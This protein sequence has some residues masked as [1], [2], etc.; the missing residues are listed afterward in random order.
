M[1]KSA[2]TPIPTPRR[3]EKKGRPFRAFLLICCLLIVAVCFPP[4]FRP[5]VRSALKL[6]AAR[7]GLQLEVARIEGSL[8]GPV[9]FYDV[10][11]SGTSTAGSAVQL[12]AERAR[13]TFSWKNL[14]LR[15]GS[16]P[17]EELRV[18]NL[19]GTVDV[20]KESQ[21]PDEKKS[22]SS[23][24][25]SPRILFPAA[26]EVSDAS[27]MIKQSREFVRLEHVTFRASDLES[28]EI[29]IGALAVEQPW[30][31]T[32]FNNLRGTIALQN[33]QAT[34]AAMKLGD[35]L[36]L[37]NVSADLPELLRGRLKVNFAL[38][39]FSGTIRGELRSAPRDKHLNF[40]SS[41]GFSQIS[42]AQLAAFLDED[43][44]GVI[45]EGKFTFRGSPHDLP[46]ATFSTRFEATDF[47]WAKR[48]W[49][50]LR[51]GA[52]LINRRLMIP[53]FELQQ[54]HNSLSLKGEMEI[55]G[56]WRTWWQDDF[57]FDLKANLGSLSELS[58][59]FGPGFA[60]VSGKLDIAGSI[61]GQRQYFS[62]QLA[63][64]GAQLSYG[65]APLDKLDAAL[66]LNGNEL[67]VTNA[68]LVHGGDFLRGHGVVNILGER[69]YWGEVKASVADLALYSPFMQPPLVPRA[70]AGG[71]ALEWSG[72]GTSKAHSG[73]FKAQFKK[74]RVLGD[75]EARPLNLDAEA[76][77]SPASIFFSK[78]A[79]A[80]SETNFTAKV[81]AT[82]QS[83]SLQG[84]RLAHKDKTWLEGDAQLPLNVWEVW[85]S[86]VS[87]TW[88]NFDGPC[89]VDVTAQTLALRE[90]LLLTGKEWPW[91]GEVTGK[92]AAKGTLAD[93]TLNGG[94]DLKKI[95]TPQ[96]KSGD[97]ELLF[98]EHYVG[99]KSFHVIASDLDYSGDGAITIAD[100]RSPD[101][102]LALHM[103]EFTVTPSAELDAKI[104]PDV[105]L[106]GP[107]SAAV[108][109]GSVRLLSAGIHRRFEIAS[110]LAQ[111]SDGLDAP[112]LPLDFS[113]VVPPQWKLDFD[114]AGTAPLKLLSG[115]GT[116][117]PQ[118][119]V[120]G[121]PA[122][123]RL[124]GS[125]ELGGFSA[126]AG[127]AK[128]QI[129]SGAIF[130]HDSK[131]PDLVL[132]L[133]GNARG[134]DFTGEIFGT[135]NQK[136][137]AWD[138]ETEMD[139]EAIPT[140]LTSGESAFTSPQ[141]LSP[142]AFDLHLDDRTPALFR[143]RP[144]LDDQFSVWPQRSAPEP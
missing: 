46:K 130:L 34:V 99:V 88:W 27:L 7:H 20:L 44:A 105:F 21:A 12:G 49:N 51:L 131:D 87:A 2:D 28:G 83:L 71:L 93:L 82:P 53:E 140:L 114:V 76:T 107:L 52:T 98:A 57:T 5:L 31:K 6:E 115:A 112:L 80:D 3:A 39:A 18:E 135:M 113:A 138:S 29:Q 32:T 111:G 77:Y 73:A 85:Q 61:R 13:A 125:I 117:T 116:I 103:R 4:T 50:F 45:K 23:P 62:G 101:L 84:L 8:F 108:V 128:L 144:S 124:A 100:V 68:E 143:Q 70:F 41:G 22:D 110:L 25:E 72:D 59:L 16:N 106:E 43:A 56:D 58:A 67:Q 109:S 118:L 63:V 66:K 142:L 36:V 120:S 79:L 74:V 119:H 33:A 95:A 123:P 15:R 126:D 11:L 121:T 17:W 134:S 42:I 136:N 137:F 86:P 60:D 64:S 19:T 37:Q 48:Q 78:F 24:A 139:V 133:R 92:L 122:A 14:L 94:L 75:N 35:D 9:L 90:T 30:L 26:L 1:Q 81:A 96:I 91:R 129:Q 65:A 89:N 127:S 38:S 141:E 10:R 69:R 132:R 47:R 55:P 40:E 102:A 97:A 54:A 104:V